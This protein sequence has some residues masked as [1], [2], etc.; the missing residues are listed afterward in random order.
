MN[1]IE[2][3]TLEIDREARALT[4]NLLKLLVLATPVDTGRARGN[5][6]VSSRTPRNTTLN[7]TDRSGGISISRAL[8]GLERLSR[9]YWITNNLDYIEDLNRGTS[10]QAP[11]RFVETAITRVLNAR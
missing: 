1:L 5:W 7:V 2:E 4:L 3:L 6:Q 9:R 8:S 10:Q 11:V